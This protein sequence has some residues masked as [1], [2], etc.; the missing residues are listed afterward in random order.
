[1][2]REAQNEGEL[3][4]L[5]NLLKKQFLTA[6]QVAEV[7]KCSKPAAYKRLSVLKMRGYEMNLCFIREGSAGPRS[8]AFK[9]APIPTKKSKRK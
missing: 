6:A 8:K 7:M 9:I 4:K 2:M 3:N 5:V 1:M